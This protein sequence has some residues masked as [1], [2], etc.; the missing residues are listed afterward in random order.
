ML[1]CFYRQAIVKK[2]KQ[3][4]CPLF[5]C[6][7]EA[8]ILQLNYESPRSVT[9]VALTGLFFKI[10]L[11]FKI[12]KVEIFNDASILQQYCRLPTPLKRWWSAV[13][14]LQYVTTL[15]SYFTQLLLSYPFSHLTSEK[16]D[17]FFSWPL[18]LKTWQHH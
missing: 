1:N 7:F 16:R 17:A 4:N 15:T 12:V 13:E 2:K 11:R 14:D 8:I 3:E 9:H 5:F 18:F 10:T 6:T